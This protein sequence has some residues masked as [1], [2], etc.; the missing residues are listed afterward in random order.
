VSS[1]VFYDTRTR[2]KETFKPIER[3]KI[4]LYVCGVTVYDRCH[5]GH[6]RSIVFFDSVVRFLRWRG[7]EVCFVRNITDI[8]DKIINRANRDG[9]EWRQIADTYSELMRRDVAALGCVQPDHEP[10]A[11]DHIPEMLALIQDL[12]EHGLAYAVGDGDVYFSVA[13]F[14]H[15]GALSGREIEDL[16][17]GARVDVDPRKRNPMDF[18]L[19]K[20]SK[21]NEP[22]WPSPW[23]AGRPGWH[24][25]CSAMSVKYLGQP[26][27]IH[28]GGEDLIFPHHENELAQSCGCR[29]CGPEGFVHHWIHHAFVR[30]DKEKMSKSLG[31][32]FAIEDVLKEVVAEGLRLHLLSTHYRS[33]LDFAAE[34]IQE[35]TRGLLRAYET[36]ARA[37]EAGVEGAEL[38]ADSPAAASVLEA[39]D[40]DFNTPKA[41]AAAFEAVREVNRA[42]DAGNKAEAA[43]ALSVIRT[44]GA[45]LGLFRVPA[46]EFL[47]DHKRRFAGKSGIDPAEIEGLIAERA[48]ARKNKDFKRADAIRAELSGRGIVLEDGPGGTTWKVEG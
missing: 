7:Y 30:I 19:W 33:P 9:V 1:L 35:S 38:P 16:M 8:D 31:N 44:A 24:L 34:G 37:D 29:S 5:V 11:T 3:G 14:P 48:E 4:G 27:D 2:R 13:D 22:S 12:E 6:A 23:G 28:G 42:L 17:A 40:D 36:I 46:A 25:E 41:I 39:M 43:T 21:E 18:A 15:Y 20:A 26:F 45:A 47:A 10:R 32:V